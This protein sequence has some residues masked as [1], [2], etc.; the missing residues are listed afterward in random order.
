MG[1]GSRNLR[2]GVPVTK[3]IATVL[4]GLSL[5]AQAKTS[6]FDRN[7]L[8]KTLM[9]PDCPVWLE[10][11]Y[12]DR[13]VSQRNRVS[14]RFTNHS[15]MRVIGVKVGFAGYD[16]VWDHHTI[17]KQYAVPM[18]LKVRHSDAPVW[19]VNDQDFESDTVAGIEVHLVRIMFEN[20]SFWNDDGSEKCSLS[21]QGRPRA[22]KHSDD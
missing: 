15:T 22:S 14:V 16:A 1:H 18:D 11:I 12:Q 8:N 4:I 3:Y 7:V 19:R 21:V 20:G 13:A 2:I 5:G 10:G 6:M 9:N 17:T